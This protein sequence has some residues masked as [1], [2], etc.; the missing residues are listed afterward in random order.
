MSNV[1][2]LVGAYQKALCV[3][4]RER[5]KAEKEYIKPRKFPSQCFCIFITQYQYS[6]Y[7]CSKIHA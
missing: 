3:L 7:D 6:H 5:N 2:K 1:Q 4:S